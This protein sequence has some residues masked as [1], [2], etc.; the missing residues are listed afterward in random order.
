MPRR[1]SLSTATLALLA[2]ALVLPISLG[3]LLGLGRLLAALGDTA[4]GYV[5]DRVAL[6]FGVLWVIDLICLVLMVAIHAVLNEPPS[7]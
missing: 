3:V 4:G 6:G 1:S 5:M 2:A 7:E